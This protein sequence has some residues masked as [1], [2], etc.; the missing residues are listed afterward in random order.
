MKLEFVRAG[1]PECPL[2]RLYDFNSTEAR[3]FQ[4]LIVRLVRKTDEMIAVHQQ[5]GFESLGGCELTLRRMDEDRGVR[6]VAPAKFD[7]GS[8]D[9][10][11]LEVAGLIQPFCQPEA[12]G[13]HW[14]SRFGSISVLFSRDGSW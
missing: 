13:Y 12:V 5:P 7:W 14:L 11:W 1:S 9:S 4:H 6:E 8:T 2:I 10:V 3:Q